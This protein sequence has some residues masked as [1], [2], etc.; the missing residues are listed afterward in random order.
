MLQ[1]RIGNKSLLL[2]PSNRWDGTGIMFLGCPSV[3]VCAGAEAFPI[4]LPSASTLC[5]KK[6]I[7]YHPTSTD[8]FN[9]SSRIPVIFGAVITE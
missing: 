2:R 8:N 5:C 4:G 9:S 7:A 1:K 3:C 6:Y